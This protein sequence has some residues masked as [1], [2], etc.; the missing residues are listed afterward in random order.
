MD[1][2]NPA[3]LPQLQELFVRIIQISVR[4][5]FVALLVMLV[6][7]AIKFITS[8]GEKG[9]QTGSQTILHAI[10][11]ILFLAGAWLA[12][13][14]IKAFTGVDVTTFCLGFAPFC[15]V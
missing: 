11:G 2:I 8:G 7:G 3:G 9:V 10:L 15:K 12:L 14:L 13:L 6:I 5:A 1:P 4:L